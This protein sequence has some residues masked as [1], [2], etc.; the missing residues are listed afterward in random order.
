[1]ASVAVL[2]FTG[3]APGSPQS[4][5]KT[6][7]DEHAG[8]AARLATSTKLF[9]AALARLA[10]SPTP[11]QLAAL[12]GAAAQAHPELLRASEWSVAGQGEEG[13]EEE[14]VPRAESQ[15]TEAAAELAGVSAALEAYA[16]APSAVALAR[17]RSKL[18]AARGQWDE[19]ISQL[20]Y[21]AH[22]SHAPTL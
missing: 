16:R 4:G 15:V 2:A 17:N 5:A 7:L 19:G 14:D 1:M 20:W 3:C 8:A 21:L 22:T 6:F 12:A 11:S 10:S 9:E 18:S 13:A